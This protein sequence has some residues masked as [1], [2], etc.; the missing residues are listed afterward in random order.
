MTISFEEQLLANLADALDQAMRA[1]VA[2]AHKRHSGESFYAYILYTS[3]LFEHAV[4]S[5]NS[6]ESLRRIAKDEKQ[7]KGL[8]WS[9]PDWEYHGEEEALFET[10]N[11]TLAS[12]LK[13]QG[14]DESAVV[15]RRSVFV[16]VLKRLDADGV[17]G[18]ASRRDSALVNIMWGDQD[19]VAHVES[20]RILNP[21]SSYLRYAEYQ[22]PSLRESEKEIERSRS[23]HKEE[24]LA[25]IRRAIKQV[26]ED[27]S[28]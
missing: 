3:P 20:A 28:H 7:A 22:L 24:S 19:A 12:L 17:F 8:Q 26:E 15:K 18:T 14:Y 23:M 11:E 1:A 6:H 27:I 4:S 21:I 2:R 9:P 5:F 13:I 16:E 10:A 25:R